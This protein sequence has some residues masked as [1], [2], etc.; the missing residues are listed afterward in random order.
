MAHTPMEI[1]RN[2]LQFVV[3]ELK[4]E[5]PETYQYGY[6]LAMESVIKDIDLQMLEPE[7]QEYIDAYN[8]GYRDGEQADSSDIKKDVQYFDDANNYFI[9]KYKK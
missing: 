8:Q 7:K 5:V 6:R 4:D 9:N 3:D 1:L 2:K